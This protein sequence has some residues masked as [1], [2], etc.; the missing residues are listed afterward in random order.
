[1]AENRCRTFGICFRPYCYGTAFGTCRT[2]FR[3]QL[4]QR[5]FLLWHPTSAGTISAPL[6][7]LRL[8][9]RRFLL[10]H[11]IRHLPNIF[12]AAADSAPILAMASDICR[13]NLSTS[14]SASADTSPILVTALHSAPAEHIFGCS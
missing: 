14:F 6:F 9:H 3:L 11:C 13:N 10:R 7:R 1:M 4:T 8:T 5:R 12:S 2:Y